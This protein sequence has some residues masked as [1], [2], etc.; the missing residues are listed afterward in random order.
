MAEYRREL[1]L[2]LQA[3]VQA[4]KDEDVAVR[5]RHGIHHSAVHETEDEGLVPAGCGSDPLADSTHVLRR[6]AFHDHPALGVV[7][8]HLLARTLCM[9]THGPTA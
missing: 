5:Q 7:I 4:T 8:E 2:G 6:L 1:T 3:G 9:R